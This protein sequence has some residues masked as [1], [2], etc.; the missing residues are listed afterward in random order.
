MEPTPLTRRITLSFDNGPH[1]EVTPFVLDTL[2]RHGIA[3]TFFVVGDKLAGARQA[4]ERAHAEGHWIG[5]HTWS[6]SSPF[7]DRGEADFIASEIDRTQAALGAL[8]H[9]DRF[10]RPFG[11]QGRLD[12]ALTARAVDHLRMGGFTCVLWN[13]VP[14][15][16]KD[17]DGWPD[18]A[19]RQI[20]ETDWP[21]LVLH[22][23]HAAAMRHLDRFLSTLK[24]RG[25]VFEQAFPP[26]CVA[27]E[28][29]QPTAILQTGVVAC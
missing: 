11:G 17:Q 21:L 18:T 13:A 20:E 2:A 22:D 28:R 16:W 6:H 14:G 7:R 19:L 29:G 26:A 5:N 3:T 27:M 23:I 15:D 4:S 9:P 1:P 24:D 8:S 12:G 10:F 25:F